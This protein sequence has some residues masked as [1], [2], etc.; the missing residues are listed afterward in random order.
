MAAGYELESQSRK[1]ELLNGT[2]QCEGV[3]STHARVKVGQC[4]SNNVAMYM[5]NY[6]PRAN[7][8]IACS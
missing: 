7:I 8:G 5:K 3:L 2:C 4:I 1:I 6:S